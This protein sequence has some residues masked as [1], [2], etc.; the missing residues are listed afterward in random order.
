MALKFTLTLAALTSLSVGGLYVA[1]DFKDYF[2]TPIQS[3]LNVVGNFTKDIPD[4]VVG[5]FRSSWDKTAEYRH[6]LFS[7]RSSLDTRMKGA[8]MI[9][10]TPLRFLGNA[11]LGFFGSTKKW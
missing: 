1:Y 2:S 4:N 11:T 5:N 3:T 7:R 6:E 9:A 10:L 8:G